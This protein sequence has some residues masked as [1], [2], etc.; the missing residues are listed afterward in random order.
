MIQA[1][2]KLHDARF[3]S[4]NFERA[5]TQTNDSRRLCK[6][7]FDH[8]AHEENFG[9]S[10]FRQNGLTARRNKQAKVKAEFGLEYLSMNFDRTSLNPRWCKIIEGQD[11]KSLKTLDEFR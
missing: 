10:S 4:V 7:L 5:M 6:Y 3:A 11:P 9:L 2:M 8:E 1:L